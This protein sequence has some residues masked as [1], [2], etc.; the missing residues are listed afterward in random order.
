MGL[1]AIEEDAEQSVFSGEDTVNGGICISGEA[2]LLQPDHVKK[3]DLGFLTS[4]TVSFGHFFLPLKHA[5]SNT[6]SRRSGAG[7]RTRRRGAV[8]FQMIVQVSQKSIV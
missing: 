6:S 4:K 1:G 3:A 2:S 8:G 7:T 5:L